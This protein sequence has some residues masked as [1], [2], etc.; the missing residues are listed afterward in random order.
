MGFGLFPRKKT[1]SDLE[2]VFC[3]DKFFIE[4]FWGEKTV[5]VFTALSLLPK[6]RHKESLV[7]F[8]GEN[9]QSGILPGVRLHTGAD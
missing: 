6:L 5:T 8:G 2:A 1:A 9:G 3:S 7:K 4:S